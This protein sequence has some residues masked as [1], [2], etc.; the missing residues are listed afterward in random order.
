M[1]KKKFKNNTP[2]FE[3]LRSPF[4]VSNDILA[5]TDLNTTN[6]PQ[7]IS[8]EDIDT[9]VFN[10]FINDGPFVLTVEDEV[11]NR[12]VIP[13]FFLS[14][15]RWAEFSKTWTLLD[16]DKNVSMPFI[17]ITRK[18]DLKR[19]TYVNG[20]STIPNRAAFTYCK[21]PFYENGRYGYDVYKIPQPIAVDISYEVRLYTTMMAD[22]NIFIEKFLM[23]FS[24]LQHYVKI[25]GHD[26][27]I[28]CEEAFGDEGTMDN[29][30]SDRFH[31]SMQTITIKGRLLNAN[32]F[33]VVQSYNRTVVNIKDGNSDETLSQQR[34]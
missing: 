31:V 14:N 10:E 11:D 3:R 21:V 27:R 15:Q 23:N 26:M 18:P 16:Q 28:T 25:N 33:K 8:I 9:G 30:E 4:Q 24:S 1:L 29:L 34:F 32:E 6:L 20:R 13:A 22:V 7:S 12:E 2:V 19:G 5:N 17:T